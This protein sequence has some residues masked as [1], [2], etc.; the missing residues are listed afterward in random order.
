MKILHVLLVKDN[1][2]DIMLTLEAFIENK[3]K[4]NKSVVRNGEKP[5]IFYL[6]EQRLLMLKS[7]V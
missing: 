1:E 4:A 7:R 6:K 5:L 3:I 2:G